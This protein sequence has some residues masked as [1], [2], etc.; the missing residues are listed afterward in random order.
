M[1]VQKND[2]VAKRIE[3][4]KWFV[5][6]RMKVSIVTYMWQDW[7]KINANFTKLK[8]AFKDAT[9]RRPFMKDPAPP[10]A[11]CFSILSMS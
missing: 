10:G 9:Y 2:F 4:Q 7:D 5:S 1:Y 3:G 8:V 11:S 6:K